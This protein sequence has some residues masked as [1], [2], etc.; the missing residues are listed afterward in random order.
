ME[1]ANSLGV[2][3]GAWSKEE[4]VLLKNCVEQHGE[5]K[6]HLV[7]LR[8]GNSHTNILTTK[9]SLLL[10]FFYGENVDFWCFDK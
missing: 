8:T 4:D 3:K 7:P 1:R 10:F 2:R 9:H 5:G 6:W